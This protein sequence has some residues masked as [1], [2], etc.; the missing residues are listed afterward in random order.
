MDNQTIHKT[1]PFQKMLFETYYE[2]FGF[3]IK[4]IYKIISS[5]RQTFWMIVSYAIHTCI[6]KKKTTEYRETHTTANEQKTCK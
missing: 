6:R 2:L 3:S 4:D 5:C 1:Y